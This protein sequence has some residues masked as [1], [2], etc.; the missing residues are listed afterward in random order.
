VTKLIIITIY[1]LTWL[2]LKVLFLNI[3]GILSLSEVPGSLPAAGRHVPSATVVNFDSSYLA[4]LELLT[5]HVVNRQSP[6]IFRNAGTLFASRQAGTRNFYLV[7]V[8]IHLF[9]LSS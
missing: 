2:L 9:Q 3:S 5:A 6:A 1:N 4:V 7:E 8:Q